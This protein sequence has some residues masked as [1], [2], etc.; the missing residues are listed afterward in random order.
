MYMYIKCNYLGSSFDRAKQKIAVLHIL[1]LVICLL[2][3]IDN[4]PA[5]IMDGCR[6]SGT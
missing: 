1:V 4:H 6:H 3:K 5:P 2:P